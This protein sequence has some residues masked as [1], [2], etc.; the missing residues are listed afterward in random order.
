MKKSFKN[1]ILTSMLFFGSA[2]AFTANADFWSIA[3]CKSDPIGTYQAIYFESDYIDGEVF[4][5]EVDC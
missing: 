4:I 1:L 5:T 3:Y 2:L